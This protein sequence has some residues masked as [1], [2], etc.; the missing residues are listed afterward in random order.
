VL[1]TQSR[2][3]TIPCSVKYATAPSAMIVKQTSTNEAKRMV[4][5]DGA[6]VFGGAGFVLL[7]LILFCAFYSF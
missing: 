2:L 3:R 7:I 4:V 1:I 5:D 6:G